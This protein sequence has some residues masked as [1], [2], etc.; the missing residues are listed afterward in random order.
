VDTDKE[1][2]L[3]KDREECR[4]HYQLQNFSE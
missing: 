1:E 4:K 3:Y 2:H